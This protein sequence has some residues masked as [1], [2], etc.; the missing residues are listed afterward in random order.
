MCCDVLLNLY[1]GHFRTTFLA[2]LIG[3][4]TVVLSCHTAPPPSPYLHCVVLAC[5]T[6]LHEELDSRPAQHVKCFEAT[7]VMNQQYV[8]IDN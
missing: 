5:V 8:N 2:T 1:S 4:C 6:V 7:F 3:L